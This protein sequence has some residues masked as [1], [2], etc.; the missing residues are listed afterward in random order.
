MK[1]KKPSPTPNEIRKALIVCLNNRDKAANMLGIYRYQLSKLCARFA[2]FLEIEVCSAVDSLDY[3][4]FPA[5][6]CEQDKWNCSKECPYFNKKMDS[7]LVRHLVIRNDD[8]KLFF[9]QEV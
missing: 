6:T 8:I 4:F 9:S 5:F 3:H 2:S 1:T 7:I